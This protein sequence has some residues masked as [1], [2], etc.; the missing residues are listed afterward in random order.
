MLKTKQIKIKKNI[1]CNIDNHHVN[2]RTAG[3]VQRQLSEVSQTYL[4]VSTASV[5]LIELP[6]ESRS[7]SSSQIAPNGKRAAP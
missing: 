3:H 4:E 1:S 5:L 2:L 7:S 6:L